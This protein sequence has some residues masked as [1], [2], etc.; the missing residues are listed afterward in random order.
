MTRSPRLVR[1]QGGAF[2]CVP[3][4]GPFEPRAL[5]DRD[6]END[7]WHRRDEPTVYL[8]L[9]PG[10]AVAEAGRH[11]EPTPPPD[12][13]SGGACHRILRIAV[14]AADLV[15]LRDP[16]TRVAVGASDAP[17]GFLDRERTRS[18]AGDLRSTTHA[19]GMIVPS[20][21]FLD[22]PS[23]ANLVLFMDGREDELGEIIGEWREIGRIDLDGA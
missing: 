6:G 13:Q 16:V 18:L 21:A 23:R 10:V 20:V 1:Y 3:D 8:A 5:I 22:D 19:R 17:F 15:D 7:R 9:D 12:E 2:R 11:L 14:D 4:N